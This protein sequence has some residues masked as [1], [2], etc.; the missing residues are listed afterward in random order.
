MTEKRACDQAEDKDA[1]V[2][3]FLVV[4]MVEVVVM[5][6]LTRGVAAVLLAVS[7]LLVSTRDSVNVTIDVAVIVAAVVGGK[8]LGGRLAGD[9]LLLL[10]SIVAIIAER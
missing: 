7:M 9:E 2:A 1:S 6:L 8:V 10:V 3:V 5:L 4:A